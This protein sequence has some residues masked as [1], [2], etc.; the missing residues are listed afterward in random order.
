[1][2]PLILPALADAFFDQSDFRE[3]PDEQVGAPLG[4][5]G[6][7]VCSR[8]AFGIGVTLG[9]MT[10]IEHWWL[11]DGDMEAG[12]GEQSLTPDLLDTTMVDQTGD[13]LGEGVSCVPMET[14]FPEYANVDPT[15][16]DMMMTPGL[17][18]FGDYALGGICKDA[19]TITRSRA[20][21][22]RHTSCRAHPRRFPLVR[23]ARSPTRFAS[24]SA[25]A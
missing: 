13:S 18:D 1:M 21:S 22:P 3:F 4:P 19:I 7:E 20:R 5:T 11:K 25:L 15:C 16:V 17:L 9:E 12:L 14:M 8:G 2:M 6:L 23:F 24:S 10:N